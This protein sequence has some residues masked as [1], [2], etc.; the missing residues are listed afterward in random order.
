M[1]MPVPPDPTAEKP[2]PAPAACYA[3]I[4]Q[5]RLQKEIGI[6]QKQTEQLL[7]IAANA[8]AEAQHQAERFKALSAVEQK[9]E[10]ISRDGK[11]APWRQQLEGEIRRQ[12][13]ALL[14]PQQ[15]QTLKESS[16]PEQAIGLLYDAKVRREIGFG[17]E[18]EERFRVIARE[19]L[20]RFQERYLEQAEKVWA[21]M[22]PQQ[23]TRLADVVKHQ[24]PTSAVLSLAYE[25]GFDPGAMA[26]SYPMLAEP[27]V[28]GRLKLSAE[29]ATKLQA[30][31]ADVAASAE[32]N[33]QAA[34]EP[35]PDSG[36]KS[37]VEAILTPEQLATLNSI[38]LRRQVVL[39]VGYPQK[40]QSIGMTGP[41]KA[42]LERISKET[43]DQLEPIDRQMIGRALDILTPA[44][45]QQLGAEIDRQF[46]G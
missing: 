8:S 3:G 6:S 43:H 36:G 26:L 46:G 21:L 4:W 35:P 28:R 27:P 5:P 41:Q 24:G 37:R 23:Q 16:F 25:I 13:E 15:L 22:T 18:Q 32:K 14:T 20:S 17:P 30:V 19:R 42:D 2:L 38:N 44:Q 10:V 45:R 40:Q 34:N 9:A 11:P 39:A 7:V 33:R 31:M 12:I 29:Q 1:W